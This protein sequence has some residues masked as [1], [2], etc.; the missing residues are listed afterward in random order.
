[1]FVSAFDFLYSYSITSLLRVVMPRVVNSRL[2]VREPA[3]PVGRVV[4]PAVA[5]A[6]MMM[7]TTKLT[8]ATELRII[9]LSKMCSDH[10]LATAE[11]R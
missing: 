1:M 8:W 7:T 9:R 11:Y 4:V 6:L 3:R 2:V 5:V 10:M